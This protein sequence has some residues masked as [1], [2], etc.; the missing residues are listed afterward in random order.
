MRRCECHEI[1]GVTWAPSQGYQ[2]EETVLGRKS[3]IKC[4]GFT[5]ARQPPYAWKHASSAYGPGHRRLVA[6][7]YWGQEEYQKEE[8]L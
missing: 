5:E 4:I 1:G 3:R 8:C 7:E 2:K 6:L